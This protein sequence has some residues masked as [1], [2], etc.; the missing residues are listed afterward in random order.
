MLDSNMPSLIDGAPAASVR[1]SQILGRDNLLTLKETAT[2]L[3]MTTEQVMG[4]VDDGLL[5]YIN[6]GRGKIRPRYRFSPDDIEDFEKARRTRKEPK[7]CLST[8]RRNQHRITGSISSST[9]V[10]FT[11]QRAARLAAK[12]KNLKPRNGTEPRH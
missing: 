1:N 10:G 5:I 9:A 2:K 7:S 8:D 11:A 3:T 12:Q 6:V 4:F